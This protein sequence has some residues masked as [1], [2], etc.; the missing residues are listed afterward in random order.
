MT[1]EE[2]KIELKDI[3]Y[4]NSG[5]QNKA[6]LLLEDMINCTPKELATKSMQDLMI[7]CFAIISMFNFNKRDYNT[8]KFEL[9]KVGW[10]D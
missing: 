2:L 5:I 3:S 1:Y 9:N 8:I 6:Y 10:K 7:N 4:L